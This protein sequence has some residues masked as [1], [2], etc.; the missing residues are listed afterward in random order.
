MNKNANVKVGDRVRVNR[1]DDVYKKGC[2]YT[3]IALHR[4]VP[5]Y[6]YIRTKEHGCYDG[7]GTDNKIKPPFSYLAAHEYDILYSPGVKLPFD[8][9]AGPVK[10]GWLPPEK[11]YHRN[12]K[13]YALNDGSEP[14]NTCLKADTWHSKWEPADAPDTEPKPGEYAVKTN[15]KWR[16]GMAGED[17]K[18]GQ[19]LEYDADTQTVRVV[20]SA[21][22]VYTPEQIQEARDIVYRLMTGV[23]TQNDEQ[24]PIPAK[25]IVF[26]D[27]TS[28][29]FNLDDARNKGKRRTVA[30]LTRAF[31]QSGNKIGVAICS[32]DDTWNDD[33]GRMV[34]ICKLLGEPMPTW[35]HGK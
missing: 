22:R 24:A 28:A 1:T 33:V 30:V 25:A 31:G 23:V 11:R 14:C 12:C 19:L 5:G 21:K 34:A 27:Y 18:T 35:V 8:D 3:V 32:P 16:L 6:C 20:R 9:T 13:H 2:T 29:V 15:A 7:T 17:I 26:F 4:S 10:A